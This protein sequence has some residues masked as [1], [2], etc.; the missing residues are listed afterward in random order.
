MHANVHAESAVAEDTAWITNLKCR[1]LVNP[2]DNSVNRRNLPMFG[3]WVRGYMAGVSSASRASLT[4]H[5][6]VSD[7]EAM[8]LTF[9]SKSPD[10]SAI[11]T[12]IKA[13]SMLV[14]LLD[15]KSKAA[16]ELNNPGAPAPEETR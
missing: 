10:D 5:V 16:I 8:V 14:N 3:M 6:R 1:D 13:A 7:F 12:S 4:Q 2:A 15:V 9:C 11:E